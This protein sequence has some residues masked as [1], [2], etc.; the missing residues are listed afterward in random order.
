[1]TST[2][3]WNFLMPSPP[4]LATKCV[5][6]VCTFAAFLNPLPL[7]CIRHIW[8][9]PKKDY[10]QNKNRKSSI[11]SAVQCGG[12]IALVIGGVAVGGTLPIIMEEGGGG[13][14]TERVFAVSRKFDS[15]TRKTT[16]PEN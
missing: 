5:L 12:G 8:K 16:R 10:A 4:A 15:L 2:E 6:F 1:M 9:T 11:H 3:Y 14:A 7:L 13:A